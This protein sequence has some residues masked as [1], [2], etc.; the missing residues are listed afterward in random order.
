MTQEAE[1]KI[2]SD[3]IDK[4]TIALEALV[5]Q[6]DKLANVQPKV[7]NNNNNNEKTNK[8]VANTLKLSNIQ[9][10]KHVALMKLQKSGLDKN[11]QAYA[12]ERAEIL[13]AEQ[14]A[15]KNIKTGT[16]EYNSLL[17]NIK[18][19][20]KAAAATR[21][22]NIKQKQGISTSKD[23]TN[24]LDRMTKQ[25]Q[26][27]DGPL[28]GIA[29]RMTALSSI[30]KSGALGFAAV[31]IA[32]ALFF[33]KLAD[34][35]STAAESE[36]SMRTLEAQITATGGAAGIT[37]TD[38]D[39]FS[40]SLGLATLDNTEGVRSLVSVMH[41]FN[42][43]SGSTFTRAITLSQD[44][45]L[46]M[47]KDPITA[48]RTLGKVLNNP[49]K[50]YKQL[51]RS[52]IDFNKTQVEAIKKA[53]LLGNTFEAQ[54]IILSSLESRFN[55]LA[56]AQAD[57]LKGDVD[58]LNQKWTQ[59]WESLG[60]KLIPTMRLL[61]QTSNTTIDSV[62]F[63]I[64]TDVERRM[65]DWKEGF[66]IAGKSSE[67]LTKEFLKQTE[68]IEK[69]EEDR[70]SG[71]F[72]NFMKEMAQS[73]VPL[74]SV[75][76]GIGANTSA[77]I[78]AVAEKIRVLGDAMVA[79]SNGGSND[80]VNEALDKFVEETELKIKGQERLTAAFIKGGGSRSSIYREEKAQVDALNLAQKLSIQ[81]NEKE[82]ET[83][84]N[85][86]L[87]TSKLTDEKVRENIVQQTEKSNENKIRNLEKEITLNSLLSNGIRKGSDEYIRA[88]IA[89]DGR[90][91]ALSAGFVEGDAEYAR[92]VESTKGLADYTIQLQRVKDAQTAGVGTTL[93]G[94]NFDTG[95]LMSAAQDYTERLAALGRLQIDDAKFVEEQTLRIR[96]EFADKKSE[97]LGLNFVAN[98]DGTTDVLSDVELVE[99]ER[100]ALLKELQDAAKAGFLV[101]EEA[102]LMR[103]NEINKEYDEKAIS[104][105]TAAFE[106][107]N[108]HKQR[109]RNVDVANNVAAGLSN[110][111]AVMGNNKKLA[112][113]AKAASL[114]SAS[115][116]LVDSLA[117]AYS[118][119]WPAGIPAAAQ[120]L[121]QGTAL[122][123]MAKG[124]NEPSF[125][126]GGVD[127]QGKG[128]G[129]SD[130]ISA[131]IASG[132][133]VM[134]QSATSRNKELL[135]RMNKGL[136]VTGGNSGG[137]ITIGGAKIIIQ[138][139]A[140]ENTLLAIDE[141]LSSY[142]DRILQIANGAAIQTIQD[143][144]SVGGLLD[145]F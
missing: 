34:G 136:N 36:V 47:R 29:S 42:Q 39:D 20:E 120:A 61:T 144:S 4:A 92:I 106:R 141:R 145:P 21:R 138:G 116:S 18:A 129:R 35:I 54:E 109:L 119:G 115:T 16:V 33:K 117:K 10:Q 71:G 113:A 87:E 19:K 99:S 15:K 134:T 80:P 48:A 5:A 60:T 46:A 62:Q 41:S 135:E 104:E 12:R 9:M 101:D 55:G 28:G 24:S 67:E 111:S 79:A 30:L 131:N 97:A 103:R 49:I 81:G 45:G 89:I 68:A 2:K 76:D 1:L 91:K 59:L 107:S 105:E 133:S 38:L 95:S 63:L 78:E 44:L 121:S 85:L 13:T 27:I 100:N 52:G 96:Q 57:T 7:N 108:A 110:L 130:S 50:N 123:S 51:S 137:G 70:S 128:T 64:D 143:E 3:S 114:F 65:K 75:L 86:L 72:V 82:L 37:A 11:S 43:V 90:N 74:S 77:D 6:F 56:A 17:K 140:S 94:N 126:F 127:I 25:V 93:L 88:A 53:Q 112:K 66:Q 125:A 83:V 40:R 69:L 58:S 132:E 98:V 118:L 26:L 8:A 73:V 22:L 122:I 32:S 14:A 142:E 139:D 84:K 102:Y 23:Y 124:L 31:G